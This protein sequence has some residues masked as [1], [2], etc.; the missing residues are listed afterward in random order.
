MKAEQFFYA[1]EIA[2]TGSFSQAARNLYVSQ[3]NLSHAVKQ[4][5]QALG[6]PLFVRSASGVVPTAEGNA[7]I[8]R[9][10]TIKREYD[11]VMQLAQT[12]A[13]P[14]RLS[15]RI[16]TLNSSRT[17]PVFSEI[18]RRR[19]DSP[20][21]FSFLNY[22]YLD[23]LLPLV[24]TCQVDFAVIGTVSTHLKNALR[25]F[26]DRSIEYH[27]IAD[28]PICA[29]VGPRNP[30][31][32]REGAVSL[33]ELYPYTVVQYGNAA[34]DPSHCLPHVTG[35][36]I[37]A[38]GEVRVNHSNLFYSTIQATSAVGLIAY[39]PE[40]FYRQQEWPGIRLLR[41]SNC[42]ITG[43]FGWIKPQRLPLTDLAAEALHAVEDLF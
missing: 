21:S 18:I 43:Q 10:R 35:L 9:F 19:I 1:I 7:V 3:P 23:D 16:A 32:T 30:L 26:S 22:S 25:K 20:V 15:L 13:R 39:T 14:P 2:D 31:Y 28:H 38:F 4:L 37:H 42:D 34:E 33:E 41:L 29:V 6:F 8:D 27:P 12:P 17:A 11:Q 24:E 5:E 36:S 40:R